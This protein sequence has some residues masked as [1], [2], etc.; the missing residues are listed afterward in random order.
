MSER[1]LRVQAVGGRVLVEITDEGVEIPEGLSV[2]DL[3]LVSLTLGEHVRGFH[4]AAKSSPSALAVRVKAL[5]KQ[6]RELGVH[7]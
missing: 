2:S 6:V 5:E 3:R 4:R 7:A 1:Y